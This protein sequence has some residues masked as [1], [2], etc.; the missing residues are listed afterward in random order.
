M[1]KG[2]MALRKA[3]FDDQDRPSKRP[4]LD[5]DAS[6]D[7][8]PCLYNLNDDC[9]V[10]ILSYIPSNDLNSF[11]I[12]GRRC[13]HA[14]SHESLDQTRSG[15]ILIS[16]GCT[17]DSLM[18]AIAENGWNDTFQANPKRTYMEILGM[19]RL[20][21][22]ARAITRT[23]PMKIARGQLT[24][25]TCLSLKCIDAGIQA[26]DNAVRRCS[27]IFPN[28]KE[29]DLS[30]LTVES[31]RIVPTAFIEQCTNL[32]KLTWN[33]CEQGHS[34]SGLHFTSSSGSVSDLCLDESCFLSG[35]MEQSLSDSIY[36]FFACTRLERLSI[37]NATFRPSSQRGEVQPV[38]QEM[39]I[40]MVR[41]HPT[42]RWL[43]SDLS[44]E[45]M[46]VLEQE[47]PEIT[48]VAD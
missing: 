27:V 24:G 2:K 46:A 37:K 35:G 15:T 32:A 28:I 25:V 26:Q 18:I 17:V 40:K 9:L 33:R 47:R 10:R 39:I 14:R 44:E 21:G 12:C 45:N 34:L 6:R 7:S 11:A 13:K 38:S 20:Q 30:N 16:E 8:A 43:R 29:L 19:E 4:R 41:F 5:D 22:A 48:F 42:L 36:M 3:V 31:P 23:S 1:Y